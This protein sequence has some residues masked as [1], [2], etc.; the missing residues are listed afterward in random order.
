[1]LPSASRPERGSLDGV[2]EGIGVGRSGTRLGL[3]VCAG[4]YCDINMGRVDTQPDTMAAKT[5]RI[6]DIKTLRTSSSPPIKAFAFAYQALFEIIKLVRD[7]HFI[8]VRI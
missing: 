8:N 6:M 7:I 3:G 1:M 4:G 5:I 2:A